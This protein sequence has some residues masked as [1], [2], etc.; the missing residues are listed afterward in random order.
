M[1]ERFRRPTAPET[2]LAIPEPSL[3]DRL[4]LTPA[5]LRIVQERV[6]QYMR[7][8]HLP[9]N[10][11]TVLA[12]EAIIGIDAMQRA[13]LHRG[14]PALQP[15]HDVRS[16]IREGL[17]FREG[18]RMQAKAA[19]EGITDTI[20]CLPD[21]LIGPFAYD[22]L[23]ARSALGQVKQ[24]AR[25]PNISD[26]ESI[27]ETHVFRSRALPQLAQVAIDA[28][29]HEVFSDAS[30]ENFSTPEDQAKLVRNM[31]TSLIF[32]KNAVPV[33]AIE[34]LR[35]FVESGKSV[36][37]LLQDNDVISY[38]IEHLP[39]EGRLSESIYK[40][41]LVDLIVQ[42][43][44]AFS[45]FKPPQAEE[46]ALTHE[47]IVFERDYLYRRFNNVLLLLHPA[48]EER[49]IITHP[50]RA[51]ANDYSLWRADLSVVL[52]GKRIPTADALFRAE[53]HMRA[54]G[55][56]AS[57]FEGAQRAW[58]IY[59]KTR[60]REAKR[61]TH[62]HQRT[63]HYREE[64]VNIES[65]E[66]ILPSLAFMLTKAWKSE[67]YDQ[68]QQAL[69]EFESHIHRIQSGR[70]ARLQLEEYLSQLAL[71]PEDQRGALPVPELLRN[72]ILVRDKSMRTRAEKTGS[73]LISMAFQLAS[74]SAFPP[75][76]PEDTTQQAFSDLSAEQIQMKIDATR[77]QREELQKSNTPLP[78]E[79]KQY[80]YKDMMAYIGRY[81][82]T[83][84]ARMR[85]PKKK[86]DKT[87]GKTDDRIVKGDRSRRGQLEFLRKKLSE[88]SS[89]EKSEEDMQRLFYLHELQH[90]IAV[91]QLY[92]EAEAKHRYSQSSSEVPDTLSWEEIKPWLQTTEIATIPFE[93]YSLDALR[94]LWP[95]LDQYFHH[96]KEQSISWPEQI[97][98]KDAFE[99]WV[100]DA[101]EDARVSIKTYESRGKRHNRNYRYA[102]HKADVL[103]AV[104]PIVDN[105]L[106]PIREGE[107][108][109]SVR[110]WRAFK[111][112]LQLIKSLL[113]I[114][115]ASD[116]YRRADADLQRIAHQVYVR[117][118]HR[119]IQ[120]NADEINMLQTNPPSEVNL[121][122]KM[123]AL[124]LVKG[125]AYAE[126]SVL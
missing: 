66:G 51:L 97:P 105:P 88:M 10:R 53:R 9:F 2:G 38:V 26:A 28:V 57:R 32:R 111:T 50:E 119:K 65:G 84:D 48:L 25:T 72:Q 124:N 120:Q 27:V 121:L 60:S 58:R 21:P 11:Q 80:T 37:D 62:L 100:H 41:Y 103:T 108:L 18:I 5:Q 42:A 76:L 82:D 69:R 13:M 94:Q 78:E 14:I 126:K 34:E 122:R 116:F 15:E 56:D 99:R 52:H 109:L 20:S 125:E 112:R 89:E 74:E 40:K 47:R 46:D 101:L 64:L 75:S 68:R 110:Y 12:A 1:D 61:T 19:L 107:G 22:N 106:F 39:Q 35:G 87:A 104:L 77:Q 85:A 31:L 114:E 81:R 36:Q 59:R 93:Q 54:K 91:L 30:L 43:H 3:K 23:T 98:E 96:A 4:Q 44:I 115:Q 45:N 102:R 90:Q 71:I 86:D 17:E 7:N 117:Y 8:N 123:Q 70:E 29:P 79:A 92:Q 67:K 24:F 113:S 6:P 55:Y 95:N 73:T 83:L 49:T 33:I 16:L 63:A 118:L